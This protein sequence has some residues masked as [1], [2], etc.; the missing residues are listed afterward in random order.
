MGEQQ[1]LPLERQMQVEL[2]AWGWRVKARGFQQGHTASL[3]PLE[4]LA[5]ILGDSGKASGWQGPEVL[6]PDSVWGG[7]TQPRTCANV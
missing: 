5:G 7:P 4:M 1:P 2:P 3:G 6:A